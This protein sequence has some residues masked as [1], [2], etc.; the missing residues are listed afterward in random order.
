MNMTARQKKFLLIA[1][2][3]IGLVLV[4]LVAFVHFI[5]INSYKPQIEAAVSDHLGMDFKINGRMGISFFPGFSVSLTDVSVRNKGTD[6]AAVKKVRLGLKLFPL[7][8][9]EVAVSDCELVDPVFSVEREADGTFNFETQA[10]PEER[11]T[12]PLPLLTVRKFIVSGGSIVYSDKTSGRRNELRDFDLSIKK[13]S[14]LGKTEEHLKNISLSGDFTCRSVR[15]GDITAT[16]LRC[17]IKARGGILDFGPFVMEA[18]G[19]TGRGNVGVDARGKTAHFRMDFK[20]TAFS[21]P[22][23]RAKSR[24]T[25]ELRNLELNVTDLSFPEDKNPGSLSNISISGNARCGSVKMKGLEV[26]DLALAIKGEK[27]IFDINP[28]TMNFYGGTGQGSLRAYFAGDIPRYMM[29]F[30]ASRFR[31]ELFLAGFSR[32]KIIKGEMDLSADLLT[33]GKSKD[34]MKRGIGGE[35][36]LK[37]ENLLLYNLDLDRLL[38][39]IEESRSF[40]LVDIGAYFFVGPFGTL[41]TK[42]YNFADIA[43]NAKGGQSAIRQLISKWKVKRGVAHTEDVALATDRNR[44][45]VKGDLD[46]VGGRFD[47]ITVAVLNKEGCATLTQK[48]SG[49]F[50]KPQIEKVNVLTSVA[51][52]VIGLFQKVK[53][54]LTRGKCKIFYT[55]SVKPPE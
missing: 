38:T 49:P 22:E 31:S 3:V 2:S 37:G 30:S 4:S 16:N 10:K 19:G 34:E 18:F 17:P 25:P 5:D 11:K 39:K 9:R 41:L 45:A 40:S 6:L 24:I 44:L 13:L 36:T 53:K 14:F 26:S 12:L 20:T 27:G 23:S 32:K 52:P 54:L 47:N 35:V 8:R 29:R 15:I 51:A 33:A 21:L 42:G 1:G 50:S 55:G 7:L 48:I 46:F 43:A 28:V